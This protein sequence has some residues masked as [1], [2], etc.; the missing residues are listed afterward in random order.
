MDHAVTGEPVVGRGIDRRDRVG[1]VAEV[2]ALQLLR[3]LPDH[4]E[5]ER[6]D[7][8]RDR[9]VDAI[10]V[11]ARR[12]A[13]GC[14]PVASH[15]S[16]A[17][18]NRLRLSARQRDRTG[19]LSLRPI[20]WRPSCAHSPALSPS[21]PPSRSPAPWPPAARTTPRRPRRSRH[22]LTATRWPAVSTSSSRPTAS[23]SRRPARSTTTPATS[24]SSPTVGCTETGVG[25]RQGRR[26]R[27]PRQG[28]VG[29]HHLPG[30]RQ[31]PALRPGGRRRAPRPRRERHDRGR[32]SG[33]T[34]ST[35]WCAVIGE[36]DEMF[37]TTDNSDDDFATK[38]GAYENIRRLF[39]QL[40][41]GLDLVPSDQREVD[42]HD[43][44][45]GRRVRHRVRHRC[46]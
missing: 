1:S 32:R 34:T 8:A 38:Q 10:E 13:H 25:H 15:T 45:D 46:R 4:L 31:P 12:G 7:V 6:G 18:V 40:Q 26:S 9:C 17:R 22:L 19:R 28:T 2:A 44:R 5:V 14:P 42:G 43:V 20:L 16:L 33:S 36:V 23:P 39:T 29:G 41:A 30:A 24:T 11:L 35:S 37:A 3:Q 21:P 27:A